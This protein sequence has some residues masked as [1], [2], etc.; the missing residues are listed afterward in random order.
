VSSR[1]GNYWSYHHPS[2][3]PWGNRRL[4]EVN[5]FPSV[6]GKPKVRL[7]GGLSKVLCTPEK[8][9][10][11]G[12]TLD[13]CGIWL[14]LPSPSPNPLLFSLFFNLA[15]SWVLLLFHSQGACSLLLLYKEWCV[16]GSVWSHKLA[17]SMIFETLSSGFSVSHFLIVTASF[18]FH[19]HFPLPLKKK[20]LSLDIFLATE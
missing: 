10:L 17:G 1:V 19:L 7:D 4:R 20:I 18:W 9:W 14:I 16:R 13:C 8:Q 11:S 5:W 15:E 2:V 12:F 3:L 6:R